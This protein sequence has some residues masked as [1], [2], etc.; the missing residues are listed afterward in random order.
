MIDSKLLHPALLSAALVSGAAGAAGLGEITLLSPIGEPLR[1]VIPVLAAGNT[2][3][4]D[5]FSLSPTSH[6]DLP[7][8]GGRIRLARVGENTR[9]IIIGTKPIA[10]PVFVINLSAAC[11]IDLQREY[12][13]LPG[14]PNVQAANSQ[15]AET[16]ASENISRS[17]RQAD[18]DAFAGNPAPEPAR[19][20]TRRPAPL[21]NDAPSSQLDL[22][23][24]PPTTLAGLDAG[25]DRIILG[26]ALDDLPPPGAGQILEERLLKMETS[27]HLLN[28]EVDKLH[29][30]LSLGSEARAI[31]DKLRAADSASG[32]AASAP[33]PAVDK[34]ADAD[35]AGWLELLLGVLVGGSVSAGV[36]HLV[37]RRNDRSRAVVPTPR[38]VKPKKRRR[39][40]KA[41]ASA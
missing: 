4:A 41:S 7:V 8:A 36:A 10:E 28:D 35:H 26:S 12:I 32:I 11:G 14:P 15:P 2:L 17:K 18:D 31:Q 9:L 27:L 16:S 22:R 37:S 5:C 13:L 29:K 20:T 30:A 21:G 3:K 39:P 24:R 33:P 23:P 25:R 1:A 38:P 6:S 19:R 34:P 40:V